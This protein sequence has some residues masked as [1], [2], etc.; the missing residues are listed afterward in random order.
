MKNKEKQFADRLATAISDS[1]LQ[2]KEVANRLNTS[3]A[4]VSRWCTGKIQ[5]SIQSLKKLAKILK[6][7]YMCLLKGT[8][9][10][11]EI[12]EDEEMLKELL[13]AKNKII[14]LQEE[15]LKSEREKTHCWQKH[16]HGQKQKTEADRRG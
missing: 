14:A 16:P 7:D 6:I 12:V 5:P 9:N 11:Q 1:G 2:Q 4:L 15:L 10:I 3:T 13:E 8:D